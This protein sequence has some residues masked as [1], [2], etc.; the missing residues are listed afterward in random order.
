[1][2]GTG[3]IPKGGGMKPMA[4]LKDGGGSKGRVPDGGGGTNPLP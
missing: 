1:V 4:P 2:G 3:D